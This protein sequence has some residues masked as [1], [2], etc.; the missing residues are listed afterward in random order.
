MAR[1]LPAL[2]C[3]AFLGA[4]AATSL[5]AT[6]Q[7][8]NVN[9]PGRGADPSTPPAPPP[10]PDDFETDNRRAQG[11]FVVRTEPRLGQAARLVP[12]Q[13]EGAWLATRAQQ[14]VNIKKTGYFRGN[15]ETTNGVQMSASF[16]ANER[17]QV[18]I[19]FTAE[20]CVGLAPPVADTSFPDIASCTAIDGTDYRMFVRA[21]IDGQPAAPADV[22]F[23]V[24]NVEGARS[25]IFTT[26]VGAGIHT[27]EMQWRV[28]SSREAGRTV[29]GFMRNA[30]LLVRQGVDRQDKS[31]LRV[32]T[33]PSGA[34]QKKDTAVWET[35]PQMTQT[36]NVPGQGVVTASFSAE[37][38]TTGKARMGIRALIDGVPMQPNDMIFAKGGQ[39]QSRSVTFIQEQV[40]G[41]L[42]TISFQWLADGDGTVNVADRSMVVV[43]SPNPPNQSSH[44][45]KALNGV[46]DVLNVPG[47]QPVP[48]MSLG[49]WV[50]AKGNGEVAVLFS[51]EVGTDPDARLD[52]ALMVDGAFMSD[53]IT[54]MTT[55]DHP[56]EVRSFVFDAKKLTPGYHTATLYWAV[57]PP[58]AGK[59][60][61]MGDRTL[62]VI[63]ETA[64]IPDLAEQT[65]LGVGRDVRYD[66]S[67]P[68]ALISPDHVD[69]GLAPVIGSRNVLVILWDADRPG[70]DNRLSSGYSVQGI[71]DN[72]FTLSTSTKAY[73]EFASGGRF[74]LFR[75]GVLGWYTNKLP[76]AG[77]YWNHPGSGVC[78]GNYSDGATQ[79][80]SEAV[81]HA[82]DD[83]FPFGDYDADNDGVLRADELAIVNIY[84][85]KDFSGRARQ[86]V[87]AAQKGCG[88]FASNQP[89]V[90]DGVI[91]QDVVDCF[92]CNADN[93]MVTAHEIAHQALGLDDLYSDAPNPATHIQHKGLMAIRDAKNTTVLN[94][95]YRLALG[96][97]TP[98]I[99]DQ[100]GF[101]KLL[102]T[103]LSDRVFVLPRYNSTKADEYFILE[104]R[105]QNVPLAWDRELDGIGNGDDSGIGV[106]HI[107][108]EAADRFI[109]PI[110]VNSALWTAPPMPKVPLVEPTPGRQ[111]IRL[112]RPW[113]GIDGGDL[114]AIFSVEDAFWSSADYTLESKGCPL[115][116]GMPGKLIPVLNTLTWADC[117]PSGYTVRFLSPPPA[118]PSAADAETTKMFVDIT[119][120]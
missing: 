106:W 120:P 93:R 27:V 75:A 29:Y 78:A 61:V 4:M 91:I 13:D 117:S 8:T 31:T 2:L 38:F 98:I 19:H 99:V 22:V 115:I 60:A 100:S 14:F 77:N 72:I 63:S 40:P 49:F 41:G 86:P 51:A 46:Q 71:D 67:N 118:A 21:L 88:G 81:Q 92:G 24:S 95:A 32:K 58:F 56:T 76:E 110:G 15:Y 68:P 102:D 17:S 11:E 82:I 43:G 6:A 74:T 36:V 42:H 109:P 79:R 55:D 119:T 34:T 90:G 66:D 44:P 37:S 112:L 70:E 113:T 30:S 73:F 45:V 114:N 65:G 35:I 54:G 12:S 3:A 28:D 87:L 47:L 97:V 1:K 23:A 53:T 10:I 85:Q 94:P 52:L 107:V 108:D 57:S 39:P 48:G 18:A 83:G 116:A 96:W 9:D 59:T 80:A 103:K 33:P 26:E 50:P 111:G 5:P 104:N 16:V 84:P 69:I 25:F 7:S 20:A 64:D 105:Q 101:Q 62:V 89:L